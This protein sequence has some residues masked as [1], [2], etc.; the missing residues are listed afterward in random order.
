MEGAF[1]LKGMMVMTATICGRT[2]AGLSGFACDLRA[3]FPQATASFAA[4]MLTMRRK[5]CAVA[6][7]SPNA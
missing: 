2:L 7:K 6:G 5:P 4:T 3:T 1:Y